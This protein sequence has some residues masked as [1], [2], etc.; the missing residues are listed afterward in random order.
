MKSK[1]LAGL[2]GAGLL[3]GMVTYPAFLFASEEELLVVVNR[4]ERVSSDDGGSKYLVFTDDEVFEITDSFLYL[5]FASSSLYG[6]IRVGESHVVR[7]AGWRL[8]V[9]SSYR[10]IVEV[11]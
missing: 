7:V 9:A 10:N 6:K 8:P 5:Q 4:V 2:V 3:L 11:K 1:I